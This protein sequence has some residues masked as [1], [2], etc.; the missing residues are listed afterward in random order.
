M[1]NLREKK[2]QTVRQRFAVCATVICTQVPI[3]LGLIHRPNKKG[4]CRDCGLRLQATEDV[5]VQLGG[6]WQ[7]LLKGTHR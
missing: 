6:I 3:S 5:F 4:P 1:T 2:C 7:V